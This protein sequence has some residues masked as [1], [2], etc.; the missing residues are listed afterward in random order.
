MDALS[1]EAKLR[2]ASDAKIDRLCSE[3]AAMRKSNEREA[4]MTRNAKFVVD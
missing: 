1:E 3:L 2:A 4:M